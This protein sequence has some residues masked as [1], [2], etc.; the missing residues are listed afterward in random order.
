MRAG[1][2]G[3]A[4]LAGLLT[5]A[6]ALCALAPWPG[7]A[8]AMSLQEALA[9]AYQYNPTLQS[10]R[11][12][13]RETDEGV[14][15]ALANWRPTVTFTGSAGVARGESNAATAS[16]FFPVYE[17]HQ[18]TLTPRILDMSVVQPLY[19]GGRTVAQTSEAENLVRA[20]RAQTMVQEEQTLFNVVQSYIDVVQDQAV[21]DLNIN[22]EQ[23]LRRQLEATL[24]RFQAGEVTR[25]DVSQAEATLAQ[26]K[27][28]RIQAEG[29]LELVRATF[30]RLVGEQPG[31]LAAP[32]ARPILP[33]SRGEVSTL[34]ARNNPNVI[35]ALFNEAAARD[36]VQTLRGQ[37][38]PQISLVGDANRSEETFIKE[39]RQNTFSILARMTWSL[40]DGGA[41]YSETRQALETLGE[42]RMEV[43][44][45]RRQSVQQAQSDWETLKSKRAGVVSLVAS[46]EANEIAYE[47][48]QQEALVGARTVLDVLTQEQALFTS[49]VQLVQAQHDEFVAEF[50]VTQDVGRLT[51]FDLKLPVQLYDADRHYREVRGKWFGFTPGDAAGGAAQPPAQVDR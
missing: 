38:L 3:G 51:A 2:A 21:L 45:A 31:L 14:P 35:L 19:R 40:Y 23:V 47:G 25:T 11:A 8:S 22:S 49:R 44:D 27:A 30:T 20:A 17:G 16:V 15:Q 37:L 1:R 10:Q 42:R 48:V 28:G 39:F 46:V 4:R 33:A 41:V 7:G 32:K 50:A 6:S 43:D 26:A 36:N 24:D 34:A 18:I 29:T 5:I 9:T 13:L 12:R